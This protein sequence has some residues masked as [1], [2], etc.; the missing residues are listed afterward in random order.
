MIAITTLTM[1]LQT[2]LPAALGQDSPVLDQG[3]NTPSNCRMASGLSSSHTAIERPLLSTW[4]GS[5]KP[6]LVLPPV[7]VV[8]VDDRVDACDGKEHTALRY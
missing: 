8:T 6:S 4:R 3:L 1:L 5:Q 2:L 7:S